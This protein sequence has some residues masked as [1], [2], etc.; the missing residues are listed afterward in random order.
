MIVKPAEKA[1][2]DVRDH[3]I[4]HVPYSIKHIRESLSG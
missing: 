4:A 1:A 2:I 3:P